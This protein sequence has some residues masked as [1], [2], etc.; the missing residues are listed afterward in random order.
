MDVTE[1][2]MG[3]IKKSTDP[4]KKAEKKEKKTA[5]FGYRKYQNLL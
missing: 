5:C 3:V 4:I 2:P 1:K